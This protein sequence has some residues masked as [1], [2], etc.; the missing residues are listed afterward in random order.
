[1]L[2][3][4]RLLIELLAAVHKTKLEYTT[5]VTPGALVPC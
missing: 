3:A 5:A 1:M 4:L 2:V